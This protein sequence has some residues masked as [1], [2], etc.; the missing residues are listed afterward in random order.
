LT[1]AV[2]KSIDFGLDDHLDDEERPQTAWAVAIRDD[3]E[4]CDDLRV[5]LMVEEAGSA[6]TGL[7]GHLSPVTARKLRSALGSALRE[8]GEEPGP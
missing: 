1:A 3:C 7:T 2:K 5:E 8:I 6:G 4:I